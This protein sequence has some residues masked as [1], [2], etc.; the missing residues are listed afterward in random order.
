ME[1]TKAPPST[2]EQLAMQALRAVS[3]SPKSVTETACQVHAA[4]AAQRRTALSFTPM[5]ISFVST[6]ATTQTIPATTSI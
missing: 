3:A 4:S 2:T 5:S 1:P 6:A